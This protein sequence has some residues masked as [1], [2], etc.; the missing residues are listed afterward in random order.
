MT[1]EILKALSGLDANN[2]NHWTA[3]GQPRIETVRMLAADGS[4]TRDQVRE[5]A[6]DFSRTNT[7]LGS[8]D[9]GAESNT[10]A[11][12]SATA[13]PVPT[14]GTATQNAT[15]AAAA[16]LQPNSLP[17]HP[18]QT[19][20]AGVTTGIQLPANADCT[21]LSDPEGDYQQAVNGGTED[22][23]GADGDSP[24]NDEQRN[25]LRY[26]QDHISELQG[27]REKIDRAIADAQQRA[28]ALVS[29]EAA[30]KKEDPMI[31]YKKHVEGQVA[32]RAAQQREQREALARMGGVQPGRSP[33]DEALAAA[34][35]NGRRKL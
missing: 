21:A 10:S 26:L 3:D 17:G 4:L 16:A 2:A 15:V 7:N 28:D 31:A 29:I 9:A 27:H 11:T 18:P 12:S 22:T 14:P 20:A 6:P 24:L 1:A 13:A 35:K 23:K 5:A 33:L 32:E 19:D 30:A 34:N 25:E 8:S